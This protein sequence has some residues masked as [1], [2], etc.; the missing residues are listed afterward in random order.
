[1][2]KTL[3]W[4]EVV[5][6]LIIGVAAVAYLAMKDM[7]TPPTVAPPITVAEPVSATPVPEYPYGVDQTDQ[8]NF[9][10]VMQLALHGNY[11]AQ[12][13]VA[14]GFSAQPYHGQQ[15][16][17]VLACTWYLVVLNSGS[18][19]LDLSD[20]GNAQTVCGK[21]EPD[22]LETAKQQA[23]RFAAEIA[24]NTKLGKLD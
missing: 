13:N 16:N 9:G 21:L 2:N 22:L 7:Q 24:E 5:S 3:K 6:G 12:R 17:P 1:M 14:Y 10:Q 15:K 18:S 8:D 23:T 20:S 4:H 11:Q 19:H